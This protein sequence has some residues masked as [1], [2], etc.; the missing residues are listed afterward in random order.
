MGCI[1]TLDFYLKAQR[2]VCSS[3]QKAKRLHIAL[4]LSGHLA[5]VVRVLWKFG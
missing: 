1:F 2:M 4:D 3:F 5:E